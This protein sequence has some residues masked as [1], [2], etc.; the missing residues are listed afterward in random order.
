MGLLI[1]LGISSGWSS[2][3]ITKLESPNSPIPITANQASWIASLMNLGRFAGSIFGAV[4]TH[5]FGCKT[6]PLIALFPMSGCWF[7]T[8]FVDSLNW[9]Y[10]SRVLGG[11]AL[12]MI[13]IS[14]PLYLGEIS[15][16]EIRGALISIGIVGNSLGILLGNVIGSYLPMNIT[17]IA[18]F[19]PCCV[20]IAIFCYLPESPHHLV[21]CEY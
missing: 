7:C 9:I 20:L 18:C 10:V 8:I 16:P 17:G 2:P 11:V 12:G 19:I 1:E 3:Y 15:L 4:S 13:N 21:K 6:T 5:H 14:F